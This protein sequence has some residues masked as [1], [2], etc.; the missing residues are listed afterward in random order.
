[1]DSQNLFSYTVRPDRED[2]NRSTD[3]FDLNAYTVRTLSPDLK[4]EKD[5]LYDG[6]L[7][8]KAKREDREERVGC[9]AEGLSYAAVSI[10]LIVGKLLY[11]VILDSL[12]GKDLPFNGKI[13]S[14]LPLVCL[15]LLYALCNS[16]LTAAINRFAH[17]LYVKKHPETDMDEKALDPRLSEAVAAARSDL[18]IPD[19][20]WELDILPYRHGVTSVGEAYEI[21]LRGTY[22][23]IPVSVWREGQVL[24]LSD[25]DMV[26]R[27]PLSEIT[28]VKRIKGRVKF[29]SWYKSAAIDQEPYK[30]DRVDEWPFSYT[31]KS[32]VE[33]T[34]R[35]GSYLLIPGYE[36]ETLRHIL[37]DSFPF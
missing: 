9:M 10:P 30:A 34:L 31:C 20:A 26:M 18:E 11:E 21:R 37:G 28:E 29:K 3:V 13:L 32:R 23:N 36:A 1:M 5:G 8:A 25:E 33:I 24:Y 2:K 22:D 27:L 12:Q 35:D 7:D 16:K 17:R 14:A 15:L 4:A 19:H 6:W